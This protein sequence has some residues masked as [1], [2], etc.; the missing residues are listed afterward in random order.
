MHLNSYRDAVEH[1]VSALE[2]QKGGPD[3]S[4]I[5]PTLRSAT[6]RMPDAPDEILRALDRRDLTAFKAAMSKMRPL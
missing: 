3:S 6:I 1:F 5:W 4:S 2:L